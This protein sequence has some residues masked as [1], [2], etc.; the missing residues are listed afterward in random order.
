ML[1]VRFEVVSCGN[2]N[3]GNVSCKDVSCEDVSW[4]CVLEISVLA[5]IHVGPSATQSSRQNS[6]LDALE[7]FL[8]LPRVA[9]LP[10]MSDRYRVRQRFSCGR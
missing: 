2:V 10:G 5:T 6:I 4:I 1:D 9:F 3:F 8:I 7:V